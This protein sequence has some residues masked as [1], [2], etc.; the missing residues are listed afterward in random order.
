MRKL[1]EALSLV[2]YGLNEYIGLKFSCGFTNVLLTT[3]EHKRK[4]SEYNPTGTGG[5]TQQLT[6]NVILMLS[7]CCTALYE[8][9][10][11]P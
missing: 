10:M 6:Y 3:N 8:R 11:T 9:K 2:I 5:L 7:K 1:R 4:Y